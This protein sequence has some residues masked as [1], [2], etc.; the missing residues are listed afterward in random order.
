MN[1]YVTCA[2]QLNSTL[3]PNVLNFFHSSRH[4]LGFDSA[5][6]FISRKN[7][8]NITSPLL[9]SHLERNLNES[10]ENKSKRKKEDSRHERKGEWRGNLENRATP[11]KILATFLL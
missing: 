9:H 8:H 10:R 1:E 4:K 7:A 2:Q 6:Y 3:K 11:G 5:H